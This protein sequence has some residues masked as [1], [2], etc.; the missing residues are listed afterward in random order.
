MKP[1]D[2]EEARENLKKRRAKAAAEREKLFVRATADCEAIIGLITDRFNPKRV[3]QWGS[4][5]HKELFTDYSDIDIALEGMGSI[6]DV[7]EL[8]RIAESMTEFP[9]HIVEMEK[10]NPAH[11][12]IIKSKGRVVY[13]RI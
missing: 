13:E 1:C 8:E 4:L 9:L 5:L 2:I 10:I 7:M 11:A 12:E 6:E 3:Y